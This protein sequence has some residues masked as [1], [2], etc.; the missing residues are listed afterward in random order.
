M[1]EFVSSK[2]GGSQP[3]GSTIDPKQIE[4]YVNNQIKVTQSQLSRKLKKQ[5]LMV[6]ILHGEMM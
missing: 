3:Q 5:L 4:G 2:L 6:D 1:E